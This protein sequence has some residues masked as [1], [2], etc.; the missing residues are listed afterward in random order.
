MKKS[1]IVI[2]IT[3]CFSL[4]PISLLTASAQDYTVSVVETGKT[5]GFNPPTAV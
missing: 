2:L 3:F 1:I 4:H 5:P